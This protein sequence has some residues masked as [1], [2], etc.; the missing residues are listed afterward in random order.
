MTVV[1]GATSHFVFIRVAM[2][3]SLAC[4][5]AQAITAPFPLV[6]YDQNAFVEC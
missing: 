5:E 3:E 4:Q 2:A 1:W 6:A